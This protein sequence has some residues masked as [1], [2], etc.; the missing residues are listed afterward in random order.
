M[1]MDR[2]F[3]TSGTI[4]AVELSEPGLVAMFRQR[5]RDAGKSPRFIDS[6]TLRA[7][8]DARSDA[9][10]PVTNP[11]LARM[12][13]VSVQTAKRWKKLPDFTTTGVTREVA[14]Q[15]RNRLL[16]ALQPVT[17]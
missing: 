5:D 4:L 8:L 7:I 16:E 2:I 13:D 1:D 12:C 6:T 11:E 17:T 3:G 10:I 14:S 15:L 9:G